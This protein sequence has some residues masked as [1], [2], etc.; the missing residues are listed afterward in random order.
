MPASK[1]NLVP[2]ADHIRGLSC[3]SSARKPYPA[4]YCQL[5]TTYV[6]RGLA[7]SPGTSQ[8][9]K[10]TFGTIIFFGGDMQMSLPTSRSSQPWGL[11]CVALGAKC[12]GRSGR[13]LQALGLNK[14]TALGHRS[15]QMIKPEDA[16]TRERDECLR[17]LRLTFQ[18]LC[19]SVVLA[20]A[21]LLPHV[22]VVLQ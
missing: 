16:K 5:Y 7:P 22:A 17:K 20:A 21:V 11:N 13:I 8:I 4:L 6:S 18:K 14:F 2:S 9:D 12:C 19:T 3:P 15:L 10:G 1:L